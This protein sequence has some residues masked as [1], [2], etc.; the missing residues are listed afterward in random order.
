MALQRPDV[1]EL[2]AEIQTALLEKAAADPAFRATLK[3]D[4][5]GALKALLGV[6]PI[7]SVKIRVVEEEEGEAVLVLPRP[8]EADELP[9][10]LL[11]FVGGQSLTI[12]PLGQILPQLCKN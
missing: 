8:F 2:R 12:V 9:E 5:H 3:A 4:P 11:D 10:E 7:P 1:D 6:D